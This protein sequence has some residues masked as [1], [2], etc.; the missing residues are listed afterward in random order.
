M[1]IRYLMFFI[2]GFLIFGAFFIYRK[3]NIPYSHY[4]AFAVVMYVLGMIT[5]IQVIQTTLFTDTYEITVLDTKNEKSSDTEVWI[6]QF[7][8]DTRKLKSSD[9][10]I[11]KGKWIDDGEYYIYSPEFDG[12]TN[13]IDL[14]IPVG[15]ARSIQIL[16]GD[17][18]G[19]IKIEC[20][21]V[22]ESVIDLYAD[23]DDSYELILPA[24]NHTSIWIERMIK[25]AVY[26]LL[27]LMESIL[28]V[29]AVEKCSSGL[30]S[31]LKNKKRK[32]FFLML[33]G[34]IGIYL[35]NMNVSADSTYVDVFWFESYELGFLSRGL[36]G[37]VLN[38]ISAYWTEEQLLLLK[39]LVVLCFFVLISY[40]VASAVGEWKEPW[41]SIVIAGLIVT[42]P[43]MR[44]IFADYVRTDVV[45]LLLYILSVMLIYDSRFALLFLPLLSVLLI[46]CNE[47][48]CLTICP[49]I[50]ALLLFKWSKERKKR[51]M[52]I[53]AVTA[54]ASVIT[55]GWSACYGKGGSTP[56]ETAFSN[57]VTHYRGNLSESALNAEYFTIYEQ[58]EYAYNHFLTK[59]YAYLLFGLLLVP[60]LALIAAMLRSLYRKCEMENHKWEKICFFVLIL[61][62]FSPLSAMSIAIDHPRYV[63][64]ISTILFAD[65]LFVAK[66]YRIELLLKEMT[67]GKI[68]QNIF[69]IWPMGIVLFYAAVAAFFST[70]ESSSGKMF[71]WIKYLRGF[72]E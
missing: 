19:I 11:E 65:V 47:T 12:V 56:L 13:S 64:I 37:E 2:L 24:S 60:G 27:L 38:S 45:L 21:N 43:C 67:L 22:F 42:N 55:A 39:S 15:K 17:S 16:Q 23:D 6:D 57:M 63:L 70:P 3:K 58:F 44:L 72:L 52:T 1:L 30:Q 40:G 66:S 50:L 69:H 71:G 31:L 53:L 26:S 48:T 68:S 34:L 54:V 14:K 51:Y 29:L 25:I 8:I 46:L 49:S 20:N 33:L 35:Q 36:I 9:I 28:T 59:W 4:I 41:M 62:A 10:A 61:C 7:V 5:M 18:Y 32:Y